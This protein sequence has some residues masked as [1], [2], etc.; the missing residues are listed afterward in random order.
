MFW[1]ILYYTILYYDNS[2]NNDDINNNTNNNSNGPKTVEVMIKASVLC[3]LVIWCGRQLMLKPTSFY[4]KNLTN[5]V[6]SLAYYAIGT[7]KVETLERWCFEVLQTS[8]HADCEA[9]MASGA[10]ETLR[11]GPRRSEISKSF[12]IT[13][14]KPFVMEPQNPEAEL[15]SERHKQAGEDPCGI[16]RCR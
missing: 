1:V 10:F 8:E 9:P 11:P 3:C 7:P 2:N 4:S 15:Y 13:D 6:G 5:H 12:C 16:R 14:H